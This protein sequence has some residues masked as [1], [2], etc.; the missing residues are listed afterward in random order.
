MTTK[1]ASKKAKMSI[2]KKTAGQKKSQA[3]AKHKKTVRREKRIW[4]IYAKLTD[5]IEKNNPKHKLLDQKAIEKRVREALNE[6]FVFDIPS[7]P[8]RKIMN[9]MV[10]DPKRDAELMQENSNFV[11]DPF[12]RETADDVN[13]LTGSNIEAAHKVSDLSFESEEPLTIQEADD[14]VDDLGDVE[15]DQD[16]EKEND[17]HDFA[18]EDR[19]SSGNGIEE[20]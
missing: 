17:T 18:P 15:P 7:Q 20:D 14:E 4:I 2:K 11:V 12:T 6:E 9:V 19:D 5:S 13:N 16:L 3:A 10:S 1:K 8:I